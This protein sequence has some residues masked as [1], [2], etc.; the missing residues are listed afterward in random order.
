MGAK[1]TIIMT[2]ESNPFEQTKSS[3]E[4]EA[5][6]RRTRGRMDA[7]LDELSER[8]T[9]RS[10]LN[11][12]LDWFESPSADGRGSETAKAAMRTVSRTVKD[13]PIPTL[14]IG[15]GLAW[16][17]M[18]RHSE[19]EEERFERSRVNR[20]RGRSR[21][22]GTPW[23]QPEMSSQ[24]SYLD[25]EDDDQPTLVERASE[26][27]SDVKDRLTDSVDRAR[28]RVTGIGN[29]M[30]SWSHDRSERFGRRARR[31]M[32]RSRSFTHDLAENI[33]DGYHAGVEYLE[34]AVEEYPLA[35]GLGFT[36]LGA[37]TGLLLPRT[38]REDQWMGEHSDLLMD[39]AKEK[40]GELLERGKVV[41]ERIAEVA[42]EEAREQGL[43]PSAA[44]SQ[45]SGLADKIGEV[46]K[47]V[48]KEATVAAEDEHLT[49]STLLHSHEPTPDHDPSVREADEFQ[50]RSPVVPQSSPTNP[51]I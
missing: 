23:V 32:Q 1:Q 15:A 30:S 51:P 8:L 40:S 36:A 25:E 12:A 17:M 4:I 45:L 10:L 48:T 35:V 19:D 47:R 16:L 41:G 49:P 20:P 26:A 5:D 31:T 50:Q 14:L 34:D 27:V 2:P 44:S 24:L 46:A 18:D 39:A 29:R 37:L 13:N 43:T 7:T 38:R 9:A 42:L 3:A 11:S 21:V 33:G 6:I 22:A 28:E